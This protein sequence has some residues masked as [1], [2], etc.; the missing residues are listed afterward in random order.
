MKGNNMTPNKIPGLTYYNT[1]DI[2]RDFIWKQLQE[3]HR[4]WDIR[5]MSL[6]DICD[7]I[8]RSWAR[9]SNT[10]YPH[11][12]RLEATSYENIPGSKWPVYRNIIV[13]QMLTDMEFKS[14]QQDAVL[15]WFPKQVTSRSVIRWLNDDYL[16]VM[17]NPY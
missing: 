16:G 4:D 11:L 5:A 10:P 13:E 8:A 17:E 14:I 15:Y 7:D 9:W 2:P 6:S 3:I 1:N 12:T